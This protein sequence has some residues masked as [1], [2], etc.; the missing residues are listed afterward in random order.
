MLR[1][2][3]FPGQLA[4]AAFSRL[5]LDYLKCDLLPLPRGQ[6][7]QLIVERQGRPFIII[8]IGALFEEY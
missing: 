4:D 5:E 3:W 1:C 7:R 6:C 2:G 8:M